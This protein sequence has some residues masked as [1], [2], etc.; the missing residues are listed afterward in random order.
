[1]QYKT[2]ERK[3]IIIINVH[4]LHYRLER[5]IYLNATSN[6]LFF[7]FSFFRFSCGIQHIKKQVWGLS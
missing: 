2:Y 1:M 4:I 3:Q 6:I 7:R 5:D